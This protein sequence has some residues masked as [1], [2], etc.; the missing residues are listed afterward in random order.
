MHAEACAAAAKLLLRA[1]AERPFE[2]LKIAL[3]CLV[4]CVSEPGFAALAQVAGRLVRLVGSA[5]LIFCVPAVLHCLRMP[6]GVEL[7]D[8]GR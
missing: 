6:L 4:K 3:R 2:A 1:G 8:V 5:E 7:F